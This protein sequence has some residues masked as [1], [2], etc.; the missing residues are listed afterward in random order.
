MFN[1]LKIWYIHFIE[2][3]KNLFQLPFYFFLYLLSKIYYI[4]IKIRN[5]LYDKRIIKPFKIS[6]KIISIGNICWGGTGKTSLAIYLAKKLSLYYK[7]A[8]LRR[9]YGEDEEKMILDYGCNVFSSVN[10]VKLAKSIAKQFDILILDDGFQYRA[11]DRAIDIVIMGARELDKKHLIPAYFFREP[12]SSLKRADI[13]IIN[14]KD[15]L[16]TKDSIIC[17]FKKKFKNL[18]IYF[19]QYDFSFF[20]DLEG[21]PVEIE[22][23]K[24]KKVAALTAIGYPEGFL[25]QIKRLKLNLVK[26]FIFADHYILSK[27]EFLEIEKILLKEG[28]DFLLITHKDKFHLPNIEVKIKILILNVSLQIEDE[29]DLIN[30]VLFR[31]K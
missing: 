1:K 21:N 31:I 22:I 3:D 8:I 4:I 2:A 18:K 13:L 9:G 19:S 28:V 24:N 15:K 25:E 14:Y 11:L 27:E 29:E 5:F 30:E 16:S 12:I 7:V 26:T 20:S 10:R 6:K 17:E 23:L